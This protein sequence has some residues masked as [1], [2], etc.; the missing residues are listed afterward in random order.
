MIRGRF[1]LHVYVLY[2]HTAYTISLDEHRL[3]S[4]FSVILNQV[5][6]YIQVKRVPCCFGLPPVVS[7]HFRPGGKYRGA[8]SNGSGKFG[9]GRA[10]H[11]K[12]LHIANSIR[13]SKIIVVC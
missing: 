4:I 2:I 12:S 1:L 5:N 7:D 3:T 6:V 10:E 13:A 8:G 9:K 11:G